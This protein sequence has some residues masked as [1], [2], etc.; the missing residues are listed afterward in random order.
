VLTSLK[1]RRELFVY[2]PKF[3]FSP[4]AEHYIEVLNSGFFQS[5]LNS[6]FYSVISI[7]AGLL[8]GLLAGYG[9]QRSKFPGKKLFFYFVIAGIPL[10]IGSTALLIPNY[11]YFTM[12]DLTDK[13]YTLIV[14]Y[15]AYNLPMSIW[16]IRG[17]IEAV[18]IEIEE[19]A[20]IDGCKRPYIIFNMIPQL[21]RPSMASA[22]LFI[23]IGAWNEFI[24]A[25]VMV[26]KPSLRSIQMAIYYYLG[27][28]GQEWGPL[29]AAA[30]LA[31]LPIIL[32]FT[33]LGKMLVSGLTQGSVKG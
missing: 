17:G 16:I 3:I 21:I 29:T 30:T 15:T 18:P 23:F 2:P 31:I 19:A 11:L 9:F 8:L 13:W 14:L 26:N 4:S 22:A 33:F 24:V 10:S 12:F 27:F 5:M 1:T 32:I 20:L 7:A 28:Y 25:T 6:L